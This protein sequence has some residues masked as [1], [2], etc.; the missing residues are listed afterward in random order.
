LIINGPVAGKTYTGSIDTELDPPTFRR[1]ETATSRSLTHNVR[2][3]MLGWI[4][5]G[6]FAA[7][8]QLPSVPDLV[9]Q[10]KVSRTVVREA[11]QALSGMN[12]IEIRPGLGC[13]VK[14][15]PSDLVVNADV[16]ASL[17]DREAITDVVAARK[18]I[19]GGVARLAAVTATEEDIERLEEILHRI[20]RA[21]VRG[22]PMYNLTPL[23]HIA[24]AAAT[25]N[26]VLEKVVSSFNLVMASGGALIERENKDPD[27]R[28]NEYLS[29]VELFDAICSRDPERAQRTMEA[30]VTQTLDA[31]EQLPKV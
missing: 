1:I 22:Q 17:L 5:D 31:L 24:I 2:D 13:F 28:N 27:Y 3:T 9:R 6:K 26:Q 25:H 7:G 29:H 12:L 21:A 30:H 20:E 4:R 23:F 19:E 10:F 18:V 11:L 8:T 14:S 16:L 15:I